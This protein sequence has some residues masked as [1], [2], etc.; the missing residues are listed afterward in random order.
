MILGSFDS[1]FFAE[2]I[3]LITNWNTMSIFC[4]KTFNFCGTVHL[5]WAVRIYYRKL[6][7]HSC[8]FLSFQKKHITDRTN[9]VLTSKSV[10]EL[11][12][13]ITML[14]IRVIFKVS[15][16][17]LLDI[18]MNYCCLIINYMYYFVWNYLQG[19]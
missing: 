2:F 11:R 16:F 12:D 6:F 4:L 17:F 5:I 3:F 14:R 13:K 7:A 15:L 18:F 9:E 1:Q 10:K 8:V 19:R